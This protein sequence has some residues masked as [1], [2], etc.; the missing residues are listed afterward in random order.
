M[1]GLSLAAATG[2][3]VTELLAGKTTTLDL[4]PF[5]PDRF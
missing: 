2:H 1:L 5:R 4:T 3:L